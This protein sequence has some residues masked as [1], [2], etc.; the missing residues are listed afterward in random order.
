MALNVVAEPTSAGSSLY[1][2]EMWD[3][4][5]LIGEYERSKEAH[6]ARKQAEVASAADYLLDLFHKHGPITVR[7]VGSKK[8]VRDV[9][10][11]EIGEIETQHW[12]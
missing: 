3:G 7:W 11:N 5:Q 1:R 8:V 4:D 9:H 6:I 10:G 2:L 12:Q